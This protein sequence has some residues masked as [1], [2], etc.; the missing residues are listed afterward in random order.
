MEGVILFA[1]DHVFQTGRMENQLFQKFN[2]EG[3]FSILPIDNLSVFEKTVSSVSTYRAII[4]DWNF[5]QSSGEEGVSIPDATPYNFLKTNKIFTLIYVYSQAAIPAAKKAELETLYPNK[6][7]FAVKETDKS[8]DIEHKKISEGIEEF[9]QNHQHLKTPFIWSHS[10]NNSVQT[11]FDELEKA[12]PNWVKEIYSNAIKD[13][14]EPNTEVIGVFQN[15][16]N[17]NPA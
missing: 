9:E 2:L 16:L 11:I 3:K 14:A 7:F 5:K 6:I 4:L 13:K 10:I 15:L 17:P 12:D 8:I 1:D